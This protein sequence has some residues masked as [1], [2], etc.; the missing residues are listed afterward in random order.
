M[1]HLHQSLKTKSQKEVTKSRKERF[2]LLFLLVDP[3]PY[4]SVSGRPKNMLRIK[5][6]A[7]KS[8]PKRAIKSNTGSFKYITYN[9]IKGGLKQNTA[10][11]TV[12]DLGLRKET[13]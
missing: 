6:S 7:A 9:I 13:N 4:G 1:V 3:D 12:T 11:L 5:S 8:L 2:F 10:E